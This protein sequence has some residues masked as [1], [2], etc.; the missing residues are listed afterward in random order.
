MKMTIEVMNHN[1]VFVPSKSGTAIYAK[2][3]RLELRIMEQ[4]YGMVFIM[5]FVEPLIMNL[6]CWQGVLSEEEMRKLEEE[7]MA[8]VRREVH[9]EG[10]DFCDMSGDYTKPIDSYSIINIM[11]PSKYLLHALVVK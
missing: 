10:R 5:L 11:L 6:F 8:F 9:V 3:M 4:L 1:W 2:H 7:F